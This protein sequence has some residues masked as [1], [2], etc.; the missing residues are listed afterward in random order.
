MPWGGAESDSPSFWRLRRH[1]F[2]DRL[3]YDRELGIIFPLERVELLPE[4]RARF[5]DLPN[6][7]E[8]AHDFDVRFQAREL[9]RTLESIAT[10][11]S[12]KA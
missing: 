7:D 11:C 8:R 12:V 6:L 4:F 9:L 5:E 2:S 10:P 1:Q 3:E